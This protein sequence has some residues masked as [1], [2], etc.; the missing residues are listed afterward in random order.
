MSSAKDSK[1]PKALVITRVISLLSIS[2]LLFHYGFSDASFKFFFYLTHWGMM[3]TFTYFLLAVLNYLV[4]YTNSAVTY[5]F[6]IIWGFNWI[7]TISFW[8]YLVPA[9]GLEDILRGS[10]THSVPLILTLIE[11]S[12]NK[13]QFERR[14]F[15]IVFGVLTLYFL[16]CLLPYTLSVEPIYHGITFD[17]TTTYVMVILNFFLIVGALEV[18]KLLREAIDGRGRSKETRSGEGEGEGEGEDNDGNSQ[19]L[20]VIVKN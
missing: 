3:L 19:P 12:L 1:C 9:N 8:C 2:Y 11:F 6:L 5:M 7:I 14:K 17:N 18:G 16:V 13:I 15:L 4:Y 10:T 20:L